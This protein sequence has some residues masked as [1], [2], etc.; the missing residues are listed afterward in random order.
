MYK[1]LRVNLTD[2]AGGLP[3]ML[4]WWRMAE[5]DANEMVSI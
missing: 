2:P 5:F 4:N 1:S 3:M